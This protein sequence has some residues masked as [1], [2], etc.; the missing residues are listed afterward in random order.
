M[1]KTL[2]SALMLCLLTIPIIHA[3]AKQDAD[4]AA[5]R[6]FEAELMNAYKDRQVEHLAALLDDDFV[7]TFEDGSTYGKLG[8]ISYSAT[9]S[10]KV[11][12]V[13][14]S[15]V[16]IRI[17]GNTAILTGAYHE[18]GNDNGDPFDYHDRFTDVWMKKGGKWKIISSHYAVPVGK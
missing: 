15:D 13:E 14:M 12:L 8:Y 4:T 3:Q 7:I 10:V 6:T 5:L 17:H 18:R 16:K 2:F 1:R 9:P 11:E